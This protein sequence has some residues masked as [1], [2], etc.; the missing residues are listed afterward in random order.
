M[1][2]LVS[3]LVKECENTLDLV[4]PIAD[5]EQHEQG[6]KRTF[7]AAEQSI[8]RN[9]IAALTTMQELRKGSSTYG[10]F[11]LPPLSL[12]DMELLQSLQLPS[13]IPIL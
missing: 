12:P 13:P 8:F 11:S 3:K 7:V 4:F 9:T 10:H 6:W 5:Q 1:T 2:D